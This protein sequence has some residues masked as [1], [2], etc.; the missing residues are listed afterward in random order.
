M[1]NLTINK[2]GEGLNVYNHKVQQ[3]RRNLI[4]YSGGGQIQQK[5][6]LQILGNPM[7]NVSRWDFDVVAPQWSS[8]RPQNI[9]GF[10]VGIKHFN[11]RAQSLPQGGNPQNVMQCLGIKL[12]FVNATNSNYISSRNPNIAGGQPQGVAPSKVIGWTNRDVAISHPQGG[13]NPPRYITWS[14]DNTTDPIE[15]GLFC[16]GDPYG[17][18]RVDLID[19]NG[20]LAMNGQGTPAAAVWAPVNWVLDLTIQYIVDDWNLIT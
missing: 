20:D 14:Y 2:A 8:M 6:N 16:K 5:R 7:T 15:N 1:E 10:V 9:R 4:L 3:L 13:Q 19:M 17:K 12:S 18:I 11:T